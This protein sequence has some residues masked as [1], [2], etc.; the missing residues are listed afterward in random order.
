M[1]VEDSEVTRHRDAV[2]AYFAR[3]VRSRQEAEDLTQET[4]MRVLRAKHRIREASKVLPYLYRAAR[5]L[6]ISRSRRK[7]VVMPATSLA[8]PA[9]LERV[10][11]PH[12][13]TEAAVR[14]RELATHLDLALGRLP[15]EQRRAFELGVVQKIVY[16][17]IARQTGWSLSK[18][19]VNIHRARKQVI[20]ALAGFSDGMARS[21]S[22]GE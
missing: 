17:E 6:L 10:V 19:K 21:S 22:N 14:F 3:R 13:D 20:A 11:D 15:L 4:F 9:A 7:H 1:A 16:A 5:N 12:H 8:D 18:V 2:L